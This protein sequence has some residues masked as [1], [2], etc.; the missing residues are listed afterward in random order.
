M[1]TIGVTSETIVKKRTNTSTA[2]SV[3]VTYEMPASHTFSIPGTSGGF[4]L[5]SSN[6]DISGGKKTITATYADPSSSGG[7]ASTPDPVGTVTRSGDGSAQEVPIE[8]HPDYNKS[9]SEEEGEPT[10]DTGSGYAVKTGVESYL[11]PAILYTRTE[12]VSGA[13]WSESNLVSG[14]GSL[15]SPTGITGATSD[16]WLKVGRTISESGDDTIITDTW[17]Y[18]PDGWDTDIYD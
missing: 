15:S 9:Q 16:K 11:V 14:V 1:T 18:A 3:V 2:G 6:E 12:V 5:R 4:P 10:L 13:T 7:G 17:Q 8:T